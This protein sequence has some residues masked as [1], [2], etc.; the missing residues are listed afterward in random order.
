MDNN[1]ET[2]NNHPG[3]QQQVRKFNYP[4]QMIPKGIQTTPISQSTLPI[5][6]TKEDNLTNNNNANIINKNNIQSPPGK[7]IGLAR[8]I[9]NK[10]NNTI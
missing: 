3:N 1:N 7:K 2:M 8:L 5:N 10:Y 9:H 6:S 4:Q